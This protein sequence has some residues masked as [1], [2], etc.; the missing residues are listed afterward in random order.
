MVPVLQ[1]NVRHQP[2][3]LTYA[4]ICCSVK[5]LP[6]TPVKTSHKDGLYPRFFEF[7][8]LMSFFSTLCLETKSKWSCLDKF[9]IMFV[10]GRAMLA[11]EGKSVLPTHTAILCEKEEVFIFTKNS[12]K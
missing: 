7:F 1:Y 6:V 10:H 12:P 4:E 3:V 11:M 2:H 9:F 5:K 8:Y